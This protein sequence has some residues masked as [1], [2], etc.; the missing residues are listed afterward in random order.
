MTNAKETLP[1]VLKTLSIVIPVYNEDQ[2]ILSVIGKVRHVQIPLAKE[3]IIVDDG[4][5]DGTRH[6]LAT[7]TNEPG[8][9]VILQEKNFGKGAALRR[10]F[11]EATGDVILIQDADLEY[12]PAEY[13][14]LLQPILDG[15]ADVVYGSRFMSGPRR[16]L[17]FWHAV[18][19][20]L[21]T[22]LSNV[23]SNLNLTD[24]ETCYKVFRREVLDSFDLKARRFGIEPEL[25][26]RIA[27]RRWRIYEIPISY[28]GRSYEEGKKISWRDGLAAIWT[29]LRCVLT[30]GG[31]KQDIGYE[32]LIRMENLSRYAAWQ[33]EL[34]G[35]FVGKKVLELGAGTG[36]MSDH[37]TAAD[38]LWLAE[39]SPFYHGI[40]V[41][42][43]EAFPHVTV[44]HLDLEEPVR[45][46][47]LDEAPDLV[48]S[49]NVIEHIQNHESAIQF[50]FDCLS[51]GGRIHLLVPAMPSLFC[52]FDEG[53]EHKRRYDRSTMTR[54]LENAGFVVD[55]IR[56]MNVLGALGWWFNG[57]LL[58]RK[59][60]PT[61]QLRLMDILLPWVKLEYRFHL[62]I[63]LSLLVTAHKPQ[64]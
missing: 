9:K 12:D 42:R 43:F 59:V 34:M 29:M 54:L 14:R 26:I 40:L 60:L 46:P 33:A 11:Q 20:K 56:F 10:G 5:T 22:L 61:N 49:T 6:L 18:G 2:T 45:P 57:K 7:L 52:S 8:I 53:L 38:R 13:P 62:P 50:A 3:I 19:N 30:H 27:Q 4:S 58:K 36:T 35:P 24:M 64:V 44:C 32:T 47:E 39:I 28:H 55:E 25:T 63:G 15:H 31:G 23:F 16:V 37:Y 41:K 21:L 51:P 1:S 17:L 48:V